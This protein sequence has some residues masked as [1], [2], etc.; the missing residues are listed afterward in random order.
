MG[1]SLEQALKR[2]DFGGACAPPFCAVQRLFEP[3]NAL[4]AYWKGL[5]IR[6]REVFK[7]YRGREFDSYQAHRKTKPAEFQWVL[8]V[9]IGPEMRLNLLIV[10]G[11]YIKIIVTI[12]LLVFFHI[13][14]SN[15]SATLSSFRPGRCGSYQR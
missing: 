13:C 2:C 7:G 15:T 6:R 11:F 12:F 5:S 9:N 14:L 3:F 1:N 8:C 4:S 10:V